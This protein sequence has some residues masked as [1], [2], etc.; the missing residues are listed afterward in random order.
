MTRVSTLGQYS[1]SSYL[2]SMLPLRAAIDSVSI[3]VF[4][5]IVEA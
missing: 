3:E 4:L 1:L 5:D 2:K